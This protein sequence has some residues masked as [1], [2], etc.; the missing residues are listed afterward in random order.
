MKR[1]TLLTGLGVVT[2]LQFGLAAVAFAATVADQIVA[3]LQ[4]QGF[5]EI[6]V[7]QTWLGRTRISAERGDASREII[8]N[9]NT[10]EILRDLWLTKDGKDTS[11]VQIGGSNG[12]ISSGSG[13][14][15][16]TGG[17]GGDDDKDDSETSGSGS[18]GNSGSGG[19][20]GSGSGSGSD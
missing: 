16:G 9:P 13:R 8:L 20:S 4:G 15:G 5:E 18:G 7:E 1:R 17:S 6:V 19:R 2:A 11:K 14:S 12:T 3:Q 10:G